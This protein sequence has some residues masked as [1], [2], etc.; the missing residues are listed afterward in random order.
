MK[1]LPRWM[2]PRAYAARDRVFAAVKHWHR[3]ARAHSDYRRNG[4]Q[5]P[6]WDEYWGSAWLKV[7]QQFG[8]DTGAMDEDALAAEDVALLVA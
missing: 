2:V 8:Q 4:P 6:D 5:D 3:F 7:R 1:S